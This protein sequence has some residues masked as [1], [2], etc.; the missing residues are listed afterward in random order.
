MVTRLSDIS[1]N[2][3]LTLIITMAT[4]TALLLIS[5]AFIA[6]DHFSSRREAVDHLASVGRMVAGNSMAAV[7]FNDS[8]TA[9]E[10][11]NTLQQE[12]D[13]QLGCTYDSSTHL[14]AEY[15]RSAGDHCL[16]DVSG[17]QGAVN[18][19]RTAYREV[20]VLHE[21][22]AGYVYLESDLAQMRV[23]RTRFAAITVVFLL[24]ALGAGSLL[25]AVL[26]RWIA[27]PIGDL[28]L[29]IQL[30]S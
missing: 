26:R 27:K 25:G 8:K 12:A 21:L 18:A 14:L 7:A 15:H 3:K 16:Q 19:D 28:G 23:R 11:L 22:P 30:V 9:A 24:G 20:I 17:T 29:V 2:R 4:A 13:I 10:V 5:A 1:V 6:Y